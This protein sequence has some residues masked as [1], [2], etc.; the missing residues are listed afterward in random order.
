MS[1]F[2]AWWVVPRTVAIAAL[3]S[4]LFVVARALGI[5]TRGLEPVYGLRGKRRSEARAS[6]LFRVIEPLV[7]LLACI[8]VR[9]VPARVRA[10]LGET[11]RHA[12]EPWGLSADE[13]L[14]SSLLCSLCLGIPGAWLVRAAGL[15]SA[16]ALASPLLTGWLP[17][18]RVRFEARRRAQLLE[19]SLP[20]AM[21]LCVLCMGAGADFPGALRFVVEEI[22]A[23]H[24][25]CRAELAR[26]LEELQLGR[27]RLEALT[28]LAARTESA[29]VRE[30]VAA[31]CQSEEKGTPLIAALTIQSSTLRQRRSVRAEELAARAGV[32]MMIP[33]MLLVASLLLIVFGPLLTTGTGL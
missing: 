3:A 4:A 13:L 26:V 33:L 11:L 14:A 24:I 20:V 1:T 17:L 30:L 9:F 16:C 22:G 2:D 27:T 25:V 8:G 15:P 29:A 21:D 23:S 12:D 18:A 5:P 10:V 19:R 32:K 28:G 6:L 31:L 7:G